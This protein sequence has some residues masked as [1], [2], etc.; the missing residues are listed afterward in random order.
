M[1]KNQE[2]LR[3]IAV[4]ALDGSRLQLSYADSAK[5]AVDLKD[6]IKSKAALRPLRDVALFLY[7]EAGRLGPDGRCW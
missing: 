1:S 7:G 4:K 2:L 3:L 5:F 6:W